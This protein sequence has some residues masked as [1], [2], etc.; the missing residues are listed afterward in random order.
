MAVII[1]EISTTI[2]N[3]MSPKSRNMSKA[4]IKP[5]LDFKKD[6]EAKNRKNNPPIT[7]NHFLNQGLINT[8]C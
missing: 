8:F 3:T 1:A 5:S 4:I 2:P 7:N 6:A